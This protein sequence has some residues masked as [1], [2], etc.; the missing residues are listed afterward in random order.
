MPDSPG[1]GG[2][3]GALDVEVLRSA[4]ASEGSS[5]T[6]G[7]ALAE[8]VGAVRENMQLRRAYRCVGHPVRSPTERAAATPCSARSAWLWAPGS[9]SGCES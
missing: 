7:E 6:V 3:G 5:Q 1:S 9:V 2:T 8:V 4:P